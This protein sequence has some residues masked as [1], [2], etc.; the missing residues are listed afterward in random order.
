MPADA[1]VVD[2][3]GQSIVTSVT[4]N[5]NPNTLYLMDDVLFTPAGLESANVVKGSTAKRIIL[6]DGY[7]FYTPINF[8]AQQI[9]YQRTFAQGL[10]A[11]WKGWNTIVLPFDVQ[12]VQVDGASIDWFRSTTDKGKQFWLYAFTGDAP[13]EVTFSHADA[14]Q[15][16]TPYIVS[17]PG[18]AWGSKYDLT[19]KTI[20]FKGTNAAI[21]AETPVALSGANYIFK[22]GLGQQSLS[23]V[24]ALDAEGQNFAMTATA[25]VAPFRA[26]FAPSTRSTQ[27][28]ALSIAFADGNEATAISAPTADGTGRAATDAVYNLNGQKVG[29][30]AQW[31][32]LPRGIYIVNGKKISK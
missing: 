10:T 23:N 9:S 30:R 2:L 28:T 4:P 12:T 21:K 29:T 26:Y 19:G 25:T 18:N 8:T 7:G 20:T 31:E 13:G 16:Y 15:A 6:T 17:V 22:G 3:R 32:S 27:A 14:L 11:D 5:A 1:A 24:Y